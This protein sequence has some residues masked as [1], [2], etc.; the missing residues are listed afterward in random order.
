V[1]DHANLEHHHRNILFAGS[2]REALGVA[3]DLALLSPEWTS[4][5]ARAE[6]PSPP[7]PSPRG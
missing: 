1:F 7:G 6:K 3:T 4:A 5:P 2:V